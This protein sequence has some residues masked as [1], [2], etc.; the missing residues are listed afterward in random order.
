MHLHIISAGEHIHD[1]FST[2]LRNLVG[3][4]HVGVVV[5]E[6][7]F[8]DLPGDPEYLKLV[9][10]KIRD[11]I[12]KVKHSCETISVEFN[13]IRIPDTSLTSVRDAIL[14]T[15]GNISDARFSFN[16][17]GG[18]KMLSLSLFAMAI[19]LDGEIYLTPDTEKLESIAIPKM[20]LTDIQK[21]PNHIQALRILGEKSK[22]ASPR[23]SQASW[24]AGKDLSQSLMHTFQPVQFTGDKSIKR[25]PNRGTITKILAP[26]EDWGLIEERIR[27][28]NKREK[29]Y[30]LTRDGAF[31]L[32]I[33]R[34]EV[35]SVN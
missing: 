24:M 13:E 32:A 25:T 30:R 22:D 31:A 17:S 4:T 5:E 14:S 1:T 21:N 10:P 3:I 6:N 7:I 28:G 19:W 12:E 20:H 16:L 2:T 15:V 26:L 23:I 34:A 29:E 27:P 9:K 18:T 33:I 35:K 8:S 11:S